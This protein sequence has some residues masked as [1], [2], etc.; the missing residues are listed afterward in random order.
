M[1]FPWPEPLAKELAA[2]NCQSGFNAPRVI[3]SSSCLPS[4]H[5]G[6]LTPRFA[7]RGKALL[8]IFD[9]VNVDQVIC[10][11]TF[12]DKESP[13]GLEQIVAVLLLK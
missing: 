3:S 10:P 13:P 2:F 1:T 9:Q 12:A 8:S 5:L 4:I 11:I 6:P 7:D